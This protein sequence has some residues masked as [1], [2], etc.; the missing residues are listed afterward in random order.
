MVEFAVVTSWFH[1][2]ATKLVTPSWVVWHGRQM[3]PPDHCSL[4]KSCA[5]PTIWAPATPAA[6][7]IHTVAKIVLL[8][9]M[10]SIFSLLDQ[11][12]ML[13]NTNENLSR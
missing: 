3:V 2:G 8:M 5:L 10:P 6:N 11:H 12:P 7:T 13:Q 9:K 4:L 1:S